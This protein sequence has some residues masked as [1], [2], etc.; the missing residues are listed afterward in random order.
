M[1]PVQHLVVADR[2]RT[3]HLDAL[4]VGQHTL[5]RLQR[6]T[7]HGEQVQR[8]GEDPYVGEAPLQRDLSEIP[9]FPGVPADDWIGS[10]DDDQSTSVS[11]VSRSLVLGS[12]HHRT[13]RGLNDHL[14]R[15]A[16]RAGLAQAASAAWSEVDGGRVVVPQPDGCDPS[17][18]RR[19][20]PRCSSRV[21]SQV[22]FSVSPLKMADC[23]YWV[24]P[25]ATGS[26]N[27]DASMTSS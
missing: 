5:E 6:Q 25:S 22:R 3:F 20:P 26:T 23:T 8:P 14:Y 2:F 19:W 12:C 1:T 16:L 11:A 17:S 4:A 21:V 9:G 18:S 7:R 13:P 27:P 10:D 24:G 15:S